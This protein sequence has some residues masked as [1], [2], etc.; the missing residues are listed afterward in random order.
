MVGDGL[1]QR[2]EAV[3]IDM[4]SKPSDLINPRQR[5]IGAPMGWNNLCV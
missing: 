5:P 4:T 1:D 2:T 3:S